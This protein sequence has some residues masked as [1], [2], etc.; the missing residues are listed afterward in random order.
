MRGY[1]T[2]KSVHFPTKKQKPA[3]FAEIENLEKGG[4]IAVADFTLLNDGSLKHCIQKS[5]NS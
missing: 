3:I 2:E 4:P 1:C 5:T